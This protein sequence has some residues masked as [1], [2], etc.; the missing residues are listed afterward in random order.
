MIRSQT[1]LVVKI[2]CAATQT[3]D[4]PLLD[5]SFK[6]RTYPVGEGRQAFRSRRK[7]EKQNTCTAGWIKQSSQARLVNQGKTIRLPVH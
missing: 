5:L 2:S 3:S 4:L 7:A 1:R 6:E